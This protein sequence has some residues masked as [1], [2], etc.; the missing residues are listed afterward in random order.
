M[1]HIKDVANKLGV[2]EEALELYGNYKAKINVDKLEKGAQKQGKIILMTAMT[3]TL[4]GEGKTTCSIGLLDG[5]RLEGHDAVATLRE[6]SLGPV[7]G[8]KG[9]ATGGGKSTIIPEEEINL[10]FTGDIHALTSS[11]NLISAIIGNHI[12][13]GNE[14]NIDPNNI[15]WK[16]ALDMNDRALRE[17]T[18]AKGK[19]N[20][21]PHESGFLITTASE[22][23]AI[24]CLA[25]DEQDFLNRIRRIVVAYTYEGQPITVNDLKVS[26]AVMKLMKEAFKPNIVQTL[27]GN[28]VIIHG[29]PFANIAHG[30]NSIISLNAARKLSDYVITEA[31]FGADLG[32]EKFLNITMPAANLN[33]DLA[34]VVATVRALKLHGGVDFEELDTPNTEAM[35]L[36][37]KNLQR[38]LENLKKFGVPVVVCINKFSYDSKEELDVL[39]AWCSSN[40]Y[41]AAILDAF[42]KG[43]E[44]ARELSRVVVDTLNSTPSK[45]ERLYD[46]NLNIKEKIS[47]IA[48]EIYR[49]D[50]VEYSNEAEVQ[51][52]KYIEM[53]Y[54][55]I[56]IC[57][58]KTQYSFSDDPTLLNIPTGHTLTIRDIGLSAGAGF[59]VPMT[60]EVMI[61]P[62]LRK[63]PSAIKME[64]E[65]Y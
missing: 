11:V 41:P 57:M 55:N 39:L 33:C 9:G 19:G 28:P 65:P 56:P 24:L 59:L 10:H 14:L 18:V 22:L 47:I 4:A 7:F 63:V 25:K 34:V 16:R 42:T 12:F 3:P 31:G 45:Y 35:L 13:Q 15:V 36:G 46:H 21:N 8:M 58:A 51:I 17:I 50:Q 20:G 52:K 29:G 54:N 61:M 32:A 53:G 27:E 38:H 62:G 49:A 23:M 64:E 44:G 40:N 5:M 6:P 26:H 1:K 43:G 60:G 37:V 2:S 30:C 48:K